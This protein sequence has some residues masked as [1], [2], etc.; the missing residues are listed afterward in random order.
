[1]SPGQ[2]NIRDRAAMARVTEIGTS[3]RACVA[4]GARGWP[5]KTASRR[6]RSNQGQNHAH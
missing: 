6:T 2:G 5:T 4:A 1:M 3:T